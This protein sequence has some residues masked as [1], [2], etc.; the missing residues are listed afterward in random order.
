MAKK[1]TLTQRMNA[2]EAEVDA[3]D[4]RV[5]QIEDSLEPQN[6]IVTFVVTQFLQYDGDPNVE[7]SEKYAPD[8]FDVS[9]FAAVNGGQENDYLPI[10]GD[11]FGC[12]L[13]TAQGLA[14]A[15]I[16]YILDDTDGA[17]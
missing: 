5:D 11:R 15:A 10:V 7:G 1:P 16:G 12:P 17:A 8:G 6:Q 13:I 9:T 4:G 2:I 3:L 14:A